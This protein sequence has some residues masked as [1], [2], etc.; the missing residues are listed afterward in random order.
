MGDGHVPLLGDAR[1]WADKGTKG[2]VV[3]PNDLAL[4]SSFAARDSSLGDITSPTS[5]L[6]SWHSCGWN[7][8]GINSAKK[9][10]DG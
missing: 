9:L 3:H 1:L 4:L 2:A 5:S 8:A 7:E 6:R 10:N